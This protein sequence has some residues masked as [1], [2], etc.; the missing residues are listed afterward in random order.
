MKS[1]VIKKDA[2][3]CS[4]SFTEASREELRVLLALICS[5]GTAELPALASAAGVSMPRVRSALVFFEESGV[6]TEGEEIPTVTEEFEERLE[7]GKPSEISAAECAREIRD[8]N[9][10]GLMAECAAL[11]GKP[12]LST[13]E[14]KAISTLYIQ[15]TLS[16]EYI[17]TLAAYL[18]EKTGR[19]NV[20][21]LGTEAGKLIERGITTLEELDVYLRDKKSQSSA[22]MEVRRILGLLDKPLSAFEK[23]TIRKWCFDFCYSV[24]IISKAYEVMRQGTGSGF[25]LPYMDTVLTNW[26]AAGCKTVED[27]SALIEK[28]RG[29]MATERKAPPR[30]PRK[31]K[32][33]PRHGDFDPEEAF[34]LALARSYRDDDAD[35]DDGDDDDT[36]DRK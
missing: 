12:A 28:T 32:E 4:P 19:L 1:Y 3:L 21:R 8:N 23:E 27:C 36:E 24:P 17:L 22:E 34:K 14:A 6:I 16:E 31:P 15:H 13:Q 18:V 30:L 26:H 35:T 20:T 7:L 2:L 10:V 33:T 25:S 9:L 11:M 29:E 5:G